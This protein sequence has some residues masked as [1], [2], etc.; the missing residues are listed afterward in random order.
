[1]DII[2]DILDIDDRI[3]PDFL[4]RKSFK[5]ALVYDLFR[6]IEAEWLTNAIHSLGVK[7]AEVFCIENSKIIDN[8]LINTNRDEIL[9]YVLDKNLFTTIITDGKQNLYVYFSQYRDYFQIVGTQDILKIAYPVSAD[10]INYQ[11]HENVDLEALR[12]PLNK[13]YYH[14]L[15]NKYE[16]AA[17]W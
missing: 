4:K 14:H 17:D 1:M 2:E 9:N 15:W 12:T 8:R 5:S 16:F 11:F 10:T 7:K 3:N 6:G 13:K